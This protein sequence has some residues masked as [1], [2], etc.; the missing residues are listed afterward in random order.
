EPSPSGLGVDLWNEPLDDQGRVN[1]ED[2][3]RVSRSSRMSSALSEWPER[4]KGS[5]QRAETRRVTARFRVLAR[6]RTSWISA[7]NERRFAFAAALSCL[8]TSPSRS[9]TSM[10]GIALL[11]RKWYHTDTSRAAC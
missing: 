1:D 9:R 11:S 8:S 6:R 4:L 2:A 5:S 10:L 3:H 7:C